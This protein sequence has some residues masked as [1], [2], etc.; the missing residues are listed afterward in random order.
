M[1][2]PYEKAE[3]LAVY[4]IMLNTIPTI[5]KLAE[6]NAQLE[7]GQSLF[8]I[9]ADL[10]KDAQFRNVYP[11]DA[12]GF[13]KKLCEL[14][15]KS[16]L[17]EDLQFSVR[18]SLII[19]LSSN[20][21]ESALIVQ[22]IK[23]LLSIASGDFYSSKSKLI[24]KYLVAD[25]FFKNIKTDFYVGDT[26]SILN[27][28][29][30]NNNTVNEAKYLIDNLLPIGY[31]LIQAVNIGISKL[32]LNINLFNTDI[33]LGE[34]T[35]SEISRKI[36]TIEQI[37]K[38]AINIEEIVFL[39]KYKLN[40]NIEN[41]TNKA[42]ENIVINSISYKITNENKDLSFISSY[43]AAIIEKSVNRNE[44]QYLNLDKL[45]TEAALNLSKLGYTV[46]QAKQYLYSNLETIDN[47]FQFLK[48]A[49][50][51]AN[52]LV[53]VLRSSK[54]AEDAPVIINA[55]QVRTLFNGYV[56]DIFGASGNSK[57]LGTSSNNLIEGTDASELIEGK[58]GEDTVVY[59]GR[60]ADYNLNKLYA[61]KSGDVNGYS[62][63]KK[64]SPTIEDVLNSDVEYILFRDEGLRLPTSGTL[65][66]GTESKNNISGTDLNDII[67]AGE[68]D[69]V[70]KGGGGVDG[71]V[72]PGSIQQYQITK[73][74]A[75]KNNSLSGYKIKDKTGVSGTDELF[76][77]VEQAYFLDSVINLSSY[78]PDLT[79]P[80]VKITADKTHLKIGESV[81]VDFNFNE[82][83]TGFGV[84]DISL[85]GGTVSAFTGFGNHYSVLF[86]NNSNLID[87]TKISIKNK[88]LT[89]KSGNEFILSSNKDDSLDL[90]LDLYYKGTNLPFSIGNTNGDDTFE[91]KDSATINGGL[92]LDQ[93]ILKESSDR[94]KIF[95]GDKYLEVEI[96]TSATNS[97]EK[98]D[99]K[100]IERIQFNNLSKAYDVSD[101]SQPYNEITN[102]GNSGVVARILYS[103]LGP[104]SVKL[105]LFVGVGLKQ[106]EELGKTPVE[107]AAIAAE[108]K[109]GSQYKFSDL[110]ML[111]YSNTKTDIKLSEADWVK[112]AMNEYYTPSLLFQQMIYNEVYPTL[113]GIQ[114]LDYF[115][116]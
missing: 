19:E 91:I 24:N 20:Q 72:Y 113:I 34:G 87:N 77:D 14:L 47:T 7:Q 98:Y 76:I 49:K 36:E 42:N 51:T 35:I 111:I 108:F 50:L 30:D 1:A 29:T 97:I 46:F 4:L 79:P 18:T 65:I 67:Y 2:T 54:N 44:F 107:L 90:L 15:L 40:D 26:S 32:P 70:I 69:D 86:K 25:Y 88:S 85:Q 27:K 52:M 62:V 48:Q 9:A 104:D 5:K 17:E 68:G 58:E 101:F 6:L 63:A 12:Y 22:S 71:V 45:E 13:A 73:L 95:F 74:Y 8:Q 102:P 21:N 78:E 94:A 93:V 83:V 23:E 39:P 64:T 115:P 75:G 99:L 96:R 37:L 33:D 100:S 53:A 16:D 10:S 109:L 38:R 106:I 59:N 66:I 112:E 61:G 110:L 82:E 31:S 60:L 3:L 80:R 89:D 41:L 84:N 114:S 55:D 11:K 116:Q 43:Q 103:I 105:P 56:A 57:I 28:I 81:K 92:G